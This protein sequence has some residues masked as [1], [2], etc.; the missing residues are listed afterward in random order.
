MLHYQQ[1]SFHGYSDSI[2]L[3]LVLAS[4]SLKDY[5]NMEKV[6]RRYKKTTSTKIVNPQNDLA[7]HGFYYLGKWIETRREQYV[8]KFLQ[9]IE[10]TTDKSNLKGTRKLLTEAASYFKM[11]LT[12]D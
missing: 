9:V 5:K 3:N 6:Y 4:F 2:Y 7:L 11:P 1:V 8:K 12:F 10:Q